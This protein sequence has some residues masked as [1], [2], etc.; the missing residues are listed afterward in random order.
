MRIRIATRKSELALWQARF[1]AA[2][3]RRL[4][5]VSDVELVPLT[6]RGDRHLDRSL[7]EIGGKGLFI[8]ELEVAMQEHRADIAVHSMKD[9]PT[10]MPEGFVIAAVL[11]RGNPFD[12]LVTSDGRTLDEL[13][14]GAVV[15]SSSLRRQAQLRQLRSD[16]VARP[17][18]GNVNSRLE[19]L[20][21]GEYG[22]IVLACAGLER[23]GLEHRIG[24][25]FLPE[26]ML[27]ACAQGVI[28]I[29]CLEASGELRDRLSLL[30]HVPTRRTTLAE[31]ALAHHLQATC[32]AP[33]AS[34]AAIGH[35]TL[36]LDALVA[37]PDGGELLRERASGAAADPEAIGRLA[38]ARLLERGAARLL[39]AR[40]P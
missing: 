35:D 6:T 28:G 18:R 3:L 38:A 2:R 11:E 24:E 7:L 29:E 15:G 16:L 20:D 40:A 27:P 32:E 25:V 23:L 8:K 12:T 13:H 31:R 10:D 1:V 14:P 39:G 21:N 9:V 17:L 5:G 33:V 30:E 4:P 36:T 22:A 26:R 19:K 37:S 34:F